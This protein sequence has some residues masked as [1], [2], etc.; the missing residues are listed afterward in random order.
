MNEGIYN[1]KIFAIGK[2]QYNPSN[3]NWTNDNSIPVLVDPSPYN[4]WSSWG[5]GQRDLFFLDADG[6][7]HTNFNITSWNYDLVYNTILEILPNDSLVGDTNGDGI[8]N[9]LDVVIMVNIA[10]GNDPSDTIA[11]MNSDGVVNVLDIV[12]L[13]GI[14]L[15]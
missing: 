5:A 9:V 7:Y 2:S 1:V 4:N 10:L 6:N 3:T 13:V 14:I 15:G 11:D 12:I 8:L